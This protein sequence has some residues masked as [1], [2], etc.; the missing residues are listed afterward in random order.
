MKKKEKT[1]GEKFEE[2]LQ[3][4]LNCRN[5]DFKKKKIRISNFPTEVKS[6]ILGNRNV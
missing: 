6:G 2:N 1:T 3:I 5:I 4:I